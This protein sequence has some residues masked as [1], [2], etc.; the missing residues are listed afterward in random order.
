MFRRSLFIFLFFI[1]FS[2]RANFDF[3]SNC[4][5]AY[6]NILNLRLSTARALIAAEKKNNPQNSVTILLD[7]Y[8][9]YFELITSESKK[10]FDRLK[11]NKSLRLSRLEREDKASPY[12]L[13]SIAVINLQWAM[14]RSNFQEYMTA[15]MEINRANN[16]LRDNIKKFPTFLPNHKDLGVI[17]ALLGSIPDGLKG[18]LGFFGIKGN[19]QTGIRTLEN[20]VN[21]L[22]KSPY[23]HFYDETVFYL[24]YIQI[25]IVKDTSAY[26]KIIRNTQLIDNASLLKTY[27]RGYTA[28]K[29]AH[30]SEAISVLSNRPSGNGYQSYPHLDYLLGL[31]NMHR[32]DKSAAGYFNN[33]I[34]T[35]KGVNYTKDAYLNLAWLELLSGD[36]AGYNNYI[37][38]VK[39]QGY[40]YHDKD[41]QALKEAN[42]PA[43]D[44][45][46][47]K[48]RLLYDGGYYEKALNVLDDKR[49]ENFKNQR[50]KIEYSY[51]S[52]RIYD[53]IG[54]DDLA[55]KFYQNAIALGKNERYYFAANSALAI[56]Q[57]YEKKKNYPLAKAFYNTAINMKN[58][59]YESSI[60]SKSKEGLKRLGD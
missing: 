13:Y 45:D 5:N 60:E 50:D 36:E 12:Y 4:I 19:T 22:P 38:L 51:R 1:S 29:T 32:L 14:I 42:D 49:T 56:G 24:A 15:A 6:T 31:A 41:K 43:P 40:N 28:M 18:T 3:N 26:N 10:D 17:N 58:H 39:S 55:I 54:K 57:I 30:N 21:I 44:V 52:G 27:I 47:L 25:D 7:N 53:A 16:M 8:V 11:S 2:A 33:Y 23:S 59:D 20:L 34:K 9:D 35:Y 48:A 46:L 37:A